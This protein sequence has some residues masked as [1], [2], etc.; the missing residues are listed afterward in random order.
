MGDIV[1]VPKQ[2]SQ[3]DKN[4]EENQPK[5]LLS[6]LEV[7]EEEEKGDKTKEEC[8]INGNDNQNKV[9]ILQYIENGDDE[10]EK[11]DYVEDI[12]PANVSKGKVR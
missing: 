3:P 1:C 5:G 8:G 4:F 12:P 10:E 6:V 7:R 2:M 9:A 11:K